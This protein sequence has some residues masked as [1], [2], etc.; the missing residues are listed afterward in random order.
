VQRVCPKTGEAEPGAIVSA[1]QGDEQ[2]VTFTK[3]PT[4]SG[5]N[6]VGTIPLDESESEA[7]WI[8]PRVGDRGVQDH[9]SDKAAC[10]TRIGIR[11]I[12]AA[13]GILQRNGRADLRRGGVCT[14]H[15]EEDDYRVTRPKGHHVRAPLFDKERIRY[16][17]RLTTL[18]FCGGAS[19]GRPHQSA[20]PSVGGWPRPPPW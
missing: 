8:D 20:P 19:R 18:R 2:R 1:H 13:H 10:S 4:A 17:V 12:V 7:V 15:Q 11:L 14:R 5:E 6:S 16:T 3:A 9:P